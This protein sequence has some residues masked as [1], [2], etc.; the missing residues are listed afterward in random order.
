MSVMI[1]IR[2][3]PAPI[4]KRLKI[5]ALNLGLSL[6]EFLLQELEQVAALPSRDEWL[7]RLATRPDSAVDPSALLRAERD[8]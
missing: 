4:H 3:V 1:Q 5:R 7:E 8:R 2:N 6:S